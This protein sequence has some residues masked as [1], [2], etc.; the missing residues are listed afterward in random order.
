LPVWHSGQVEGFTELD[1]DPHLRTAHPP[2]CRQ[3]V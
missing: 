1:S 3:R 2:G